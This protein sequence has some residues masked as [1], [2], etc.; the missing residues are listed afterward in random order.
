MGY[1]LLLRG[2]YI[3]ICGVFCDILVYL[4]FL[5]EVGGESFRSLLGLGY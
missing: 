3:G 2:I 4:F 1:G 5:R